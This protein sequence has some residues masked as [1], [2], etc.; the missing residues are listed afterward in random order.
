MGKA[1]VTVKIMPDTVEADLDGIEQAALEKIASF[2]G[3][4]ETKTE[5]E[6]VAFGLKAVKITFVMD[7]DQGSP[8]SLEK[9]IQALDGVMSCETVDVRRAIG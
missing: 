7:E 2:T 8:E 1:V 6:P 5:V 3:N 4:D 9:E